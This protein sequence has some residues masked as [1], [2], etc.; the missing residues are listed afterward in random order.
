MW[1][2]LDMSGFNI[3]CELHASVE[4]SD[5]DFDFFRYRVKWN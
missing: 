3:S 2:Q 5:H 1:A 4:S